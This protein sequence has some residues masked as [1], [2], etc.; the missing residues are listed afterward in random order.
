MAESFAELFAESVKDASF[1]QG[2]VKKAKVIDIIPDFV[3]QG[4]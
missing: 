3:I 2:V 4:V 1:E